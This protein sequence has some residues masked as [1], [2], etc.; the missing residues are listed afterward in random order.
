MV[1]AFDHPADNL[2]PVTD[3]ELGDLDWARLGERMKDC[4]EQ[5]LG[6]SQA[7]LAKAA[8]VSVGTVQNF[9]RGRV[10]DTWPRRLGRVVDA[11]GWSPRSEMDVLRGGAPT[12][13]P[14]RGGEAAETDLIYILRHVA[15]AGPRTL[16]AMRAVLEVD[17]ENEQA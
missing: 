3:Q 12:E 17:V 14:P 2:P 15:A 7:E 5:V 8:N 13:A 16:R 11:L 4:R 1:P 9:E 6:L 10:P